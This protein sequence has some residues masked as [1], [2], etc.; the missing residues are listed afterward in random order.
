MKILILTAAIASFALSGQVS[1]QSL[2][3]TTDIPIS[4]AGYQFPSVSSDGAGGGIVR[5]N[6][7]GGMLLHWFDAKGDVKATIEITL[8]AEITH[9]DEVLM[10]TPKRFYVPITTAAGPVLRRYN[11]GK[12][13]T[14][15]FIDTPVTAAESSSLTNQ[16]FLDSTDKLGFTLLEFA[17]GNLKVRR[18]KH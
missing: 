5:G 15:T 13:G 9:V 14:V 4:Q 1:A 10:T 18:F 6:F 7:T 11:L 17:S 16:N 8:G 2:R 3:W 12:N